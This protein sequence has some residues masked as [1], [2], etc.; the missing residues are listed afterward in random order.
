MNSIVDKLNNKYV[1]AVISL[2]F[3]V[4]MGRRFLG[5]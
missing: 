1:L 4:G 2:L 5:R 3:L